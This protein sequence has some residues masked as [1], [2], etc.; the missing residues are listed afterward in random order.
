LVRAEKEKKAG[1]KESVV[2]KWIDRDL[3]MADVSF[4]DLG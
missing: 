1:K 3:E 2:Y 4:V